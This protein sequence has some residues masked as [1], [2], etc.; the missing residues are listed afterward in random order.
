M[1]LQESKT[2]S[3]GLQR[4]GGNKGPPFLQGRLSQ[5]CY[6]GYNHMIDE[7]FVKHRK[8]MADG[9]AEFFKMVMEYT[10]FSCYFHE[11]VISRFNKEEGFPLRI[12]GGW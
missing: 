7:V 12:D 3:I 8:A 1:L 9:A 10:R 6:F 2:F 11:E 5:V 4:F